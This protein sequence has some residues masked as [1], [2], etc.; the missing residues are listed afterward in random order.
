MGADCWGR[1]TWQKDCG[2]KAVRWN[3]RGEDNADEIAHPTV[4]T[5]DLA[6][7][8]AMIDVSVCCWVTGRSKVVANS[9]RRV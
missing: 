4:R 8:T 9:C 1:Q 3:G 6:V 7:R 2:R 5:S